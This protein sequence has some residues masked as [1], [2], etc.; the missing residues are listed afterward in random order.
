MPIAC[1][2]K[3]RISWT[4]VSKALQKSSKIAP[5]T[6]PFSK[7]I[8]HLSVIATIIPSEDKPL[9]KPHSDE[10]LKGEEL[11]MWSSIIM[12]TW[13]SSNLANMDSS[14]YLADLQTFFG[15]TQFLSHFIPNLASVSAILL[16]P[17]AHQWAVQQIN[18]LVT[19]PNSLC[20]FDSSKP[21]TIQLYP[22]QCGLSAVL[23][24]DNCS[25]DYCSKFVT[26]T[27]TCYSNIEEKM[28]AVVH[29]LEK[30]HYYAYGRHVIVESDH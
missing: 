13:D 7:A 21:V 25:V 2:F 22:S 11:H 20:Y 16:G 26:E 24:Q 3:G 14:T 17:R 30:L 18:G 1:N 19:S 28:L 6:G 23:I 4:T 12:P 5:I 10:F 29:G 27:E 8:F 9:L 15:M